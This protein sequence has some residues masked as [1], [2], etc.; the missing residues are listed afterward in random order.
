MKILHDPK[1]VSELEDKFLFIDTNTLIA[2][3]NNK[4]FLEIFY[5]WKSK[6]CAFVT[7]P[8]VLF[9][10]TRGTDSI[11]AFNQRVSFIKQIGVGIYPIERF[12]D[13]TK[14]LT[15]VL[16]KIRGN[17]S[18]TDFLLIVSIYK[19][20]T[21]YL[22]TE[23]HKDFPI[24]ILDRKFIITLDNDKDIRNYGIYCFSNEKF[25]KAAARILRN[26]PIIF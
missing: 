24:E 7:I 10:F 2:I 20:P 6:S 5:E 18:Y 12:L 25:D 16:Q 13:Q 4:N 11:A 22:I 19:F 9:E 17:L 26:E 1:L 15:V 21:S 23:N 8:S 14:D 3:V